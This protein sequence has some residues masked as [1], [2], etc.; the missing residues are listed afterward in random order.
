MPHILIMSASVRIGRR[1]PRVALH[2]VQAITARGD[3]TCAVLDLAEQDFPIF[4]ERLKNL[5]DAPAAL[6]DYATR[7]AQADG[8][9]IVTPEYNGG[10]PASLKNAI[11]VLN[12]Q[13]HR[14]PVA[15][16]T[17]SDGSFGGSQVITSL[18]FSLWKLGAWTVPAMLP[19][20]KVQDAFD[21]AGNAFAPADWV[22]RT[23]RFLDEL[24][25]CITANDRMR[26]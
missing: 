26:E 20:P 13:W 24:M 22:R 9:I 16:C 4:N 12:D 14:K 5:T 18:Q 19:V 25:W 15:I 17:V 6:K 23:T 8:V 2:L 10:Y 1:S 3:A 7:V 21:E 11:D